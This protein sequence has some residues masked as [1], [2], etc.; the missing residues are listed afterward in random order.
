MSQLLADDGSEEDTSKY[1]IFTIGTVCYGLD[2]RTVTE[3]IG[4]QGITPVPEV[5]DYVRGV[6]NLRGKVIPVMD[7]RARFRLEAQ[8][9]HERT[10]IV[11]IEVGGSSIGLVV[12]AVSEVLNIVDA[13]IEP[14]PHVGLGP[15]NRF[16]SGLGK[17]GDG[18]KLILNA[19]MLIDVDRKLA[20]NETVAEAS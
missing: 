11:V 13:D 7:V 12:D 14:P 17:V 4:L 1:L 8:A 2:V 20:Q 19:G 18:V 9:Y 6:I 15:D 16:I 5:P 10:C 3:I